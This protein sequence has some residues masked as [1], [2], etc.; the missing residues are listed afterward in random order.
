MNG[1]NE[2]KA[3]THLHELMLRPFRRY[4]STTDD[5]RQSNLGGKASAHSTE[6]RSAEEKEERRTKN[7]T[8]SEVQHVRT[9]DDLALSF[10]QHL[11][12]LKRDEAT[13]RFGS[14]LDNPTKLP[15]YAPSF[16]GRYVAEAEVRR[17]TGLQCVVDLRRR[18]CTN[19]SDNLA[20][21]RIVGLLQ[22][23]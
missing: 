9:L 10:A 14:L 17:S 4:N 1:G 21:R 22:R 3:T 8:Y 19:S 12:H 5:P 2:R 7:R 15:Q 23:T 6:N 20:R 13:E 18:G 16:R 11:A